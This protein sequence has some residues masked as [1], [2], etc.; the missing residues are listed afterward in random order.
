MWREQE[1]PGEGDVAGMRWGRTC[2]EGGATAGGMM[3]LP[4]MARILNFIL[5]Y[6]GIRGFQAIVIFHFQKILGK[7]G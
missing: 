3:A 2:V 7:Q 1:A 6:R 5:K 4:A